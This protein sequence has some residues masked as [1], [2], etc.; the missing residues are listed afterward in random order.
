M[1]NNNN[2]QNYTWYAQGINNNRQNYTW[3]TQGNT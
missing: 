3:Y 2:R 1:N